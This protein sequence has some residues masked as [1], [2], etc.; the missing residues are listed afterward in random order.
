MLSSWRY[1][2]GME[3]ISLDAAYCGDHPEALPGEYILL[4]VSDNGCGMGK[5]TLAQIFEPFFT[6]KKKDKG[7]GLGAGHR[8]WHHPAKQRL[9]QRVQ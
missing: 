4:V 5:E 7:T 2:T 8:V 1:V 9:C 6:T 3:N